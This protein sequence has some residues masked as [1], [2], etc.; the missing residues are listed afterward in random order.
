ML[1]DIG[2]HGYSKQVVNEIPVNGEYKKNKKVKYYGGIQEA[3]S[4]YKLAKHY[5]LLDFDIDYLNSGGK[6]FPWDI[7]ARFLIS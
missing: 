2:L 7:E 4:R 5:Q 6:M 3:L 1:L